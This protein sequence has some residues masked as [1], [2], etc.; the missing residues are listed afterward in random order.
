MYGG[1]KKPLSQRSVRTL[2]ECRSRTCAEQAFAS[3]LSTVASWS[4]RGIA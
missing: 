4:W 2:P 1:S 3:M